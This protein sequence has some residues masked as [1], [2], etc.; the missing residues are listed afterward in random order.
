MIYFVQASTGPI[1]IGFTDNWGL[2]RAAL[3]LATPEPL[4]VLLVVDG[5]RSDEA[6]LHRA[7]QA[8][9][10]RGEWFAPSSELLAYIQSR[11]IERV[12]FTESRRPVFLLREEAS[13][14][15]VICDA[16]RAR[17]VTSVAPLSGVHLSRLYAFLKGSDLNPENR[18]RL[19]AVM[20]EV[21]D[22]VWLAFVAPVPAEATP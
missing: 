11:M 13:P 6:G 20:P 1:K 15:A 14:H 7:F 12:T 9:R 22:T 4:S 8:D 19:R 17:G 21:P 10:I 16:I 18:G 5:Q 2:R 3:Q